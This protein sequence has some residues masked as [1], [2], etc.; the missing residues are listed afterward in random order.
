MA[1]YKYGAYLAASQDPAFDREFTPE[2]CPHIP[3]YIAAWHV[4]ARLSPKNPD[5]CRR[6][7]IIS[8]PQGRVLSY[9]G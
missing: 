8:M 1:L 6:R 5:L 3:A 9:G 7:T 2:W 4:G